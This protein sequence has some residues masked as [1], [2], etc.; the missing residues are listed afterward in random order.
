[1]LVGNAWQ[2]RQYD[3]CLLKEGYTIE[4]LVDLASNALLDAIQQVQNYVIICGSGNNGADGYALG[5]KLKQQGKQVQIISM[6]HTQGSYANQYYRNKCSSMLEI[7]D[8]TKSYHSLFEQAELIIDAM[9]GFGFHGALPLKYK[10][11]IQEIKPF[12]KKV[13][14]VDLPSGMHCDDGV[15]EDAVKAQTTI[16]LSAWKECFLNPDTKAYTGHIILKQLEVKDQSEACMLSTMLHDVWIHEHVKRKTYHGHKGTYGKVLHITGS[17]MYRGAAILAAKASVYSG[18]GLVCVTS[19]EEVFTPLIATVPECT[20]LP[21]NQSVIEYAN[22]DAILLG[23]GL[24][25]NEETIRYV[26][27]VLH[28]YHGKVVLD[29]DAISV[30]SKHLDWLKE[31]TAQV[32][33]TPHFIE[34]DRLTHEFP[35]V[36]RLQRLILFTQKYHCTVVLKGPN[37]RICDGTQMVCNTQKDKAMATAGMGDVLAGMCTSF[38]G[39]GYSLFEAGAVAAYI[40]GSCGAKLGKENDTA[41]PSKVI[42]EIPKIMY[43]YTR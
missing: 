18:S 7:Y 38:L 41:I 8:E 39:Q 23:S 33:L 6:E 10:T 28:H 20:L 4:Q 17:S 15:K 12:Y 36:D 32:L 9:F 21:R 40:H 1:M 35:Q 24:G 11:I 29:G 25:M 34:F 22:Y 2:M 14:A 42:E 43:F 30:I 37:T 26:D 5:I 31:T 3:E 13:V 27:D 19:K 16:T